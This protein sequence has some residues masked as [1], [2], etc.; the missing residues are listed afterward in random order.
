M[1][2]IPVGSA[3]PN[4][5]VWTAAAKSAAA[6]NVT[7]VF[8]LICIYHLCVFYRKEIIVPEALGFT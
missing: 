4:A 8:V 6:L 7:T 5:A 3:E 2:F 1:A